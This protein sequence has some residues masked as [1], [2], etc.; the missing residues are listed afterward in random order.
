MPINKQEELEQMI[1]SLPLKWYL[2]ELNIYW[3]SQIGKDGCW[4]ARYDNSS[5]YIGKGETAKEAVSKLLEYL[6]KDEKIT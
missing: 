1:N 4:I 6:L 2:G 3:D 5:Q